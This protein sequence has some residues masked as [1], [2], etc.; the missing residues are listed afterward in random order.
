MSWF[1]SRMIEK[2]SKFWFMYQP[3]FNRDAPNP[4]FLESIP[5][6]DS[7]LN[8]LEESKT[9]I[10]LSFRFLFFIFLSFYFQF[11]LVICVGFLSILDLKSLLEEFNSQ[12]LRYQMISRRSSKTC[13]DY[14][15]LLTWYIFLY[16][17][18]KYQLSVVKYKYNIFTCKTCTR[19]SSLVILIRN[20][21]S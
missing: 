15:T 8:G 7:E 13:K 21:D 18:Y 10:E 17:K 4:V 6:L 3:L 9:R 20:H 2:T 14:S 1:F 19:P 12:L 5:I 16:L 11:L